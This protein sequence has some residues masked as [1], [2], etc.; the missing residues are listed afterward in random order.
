[1][2]ELQSFMK[3]ASG[4]EERLKRVENLVDRLMDVLTK[5]GICPE[6]GSKLTTEP[7]TLH[8]G[9]MYGWKKGVHG[10]RYKCP[11]CGYEAWFREEGG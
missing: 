5:A 6:C 10:T 7:K 9:W 8:Y 2:G 3:W 11:R 1:M 4:I